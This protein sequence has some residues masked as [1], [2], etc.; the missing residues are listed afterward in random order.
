MNA[1]VKIDTL[2]QSAT[3][4][5]N[6]LALLAAF[7]CSA[8]KDIRP[9]LNGVLIEV[10]NGGAFVV[11]C[12]GTIIC[13]IKQHAGAVPDFSVIVPNDV[14][15]RINKKSDTIELTYE[16]DKDRWTID[17]IRFAPL[18]GRYPDWRRVMSEPDDVQHKF[19]IH[20]DL[21]NSGFKAVKTFYG[22]KVIPDILSCEKGSAVIMHAG[23][24]VFVI[25]I[26]GIRSNHQP[27]YV[28]MT[29]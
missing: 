9:Y 4:N 8:D 1:Q 28:G 3:I 24:D 14:I 12:D 21:F 19:Q 15:K 16:E 5:L 23:D 25:K 29:F 18:E 2:F 27:Q 13:V 22:A 7:E 6:P 20:P 26:M 17:G 11:G 10:R